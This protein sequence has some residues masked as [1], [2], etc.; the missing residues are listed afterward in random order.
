[1][2]GRSDPLGAPDW[3][4]WCSPLV[5]LF[6]AALAGWFWRTG[7]RHYRSSGS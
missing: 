7:V 3:L 6:F 1:M 4:R 2:L 5:A